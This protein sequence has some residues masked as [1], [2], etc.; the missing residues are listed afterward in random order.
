MAVGFRVF[1]RTSGKKKVYYVRILDNSGKV[2][3]TLSTGETNQYRAHA[4]AKEH[5]H[6]YDPSVK[7]PTL[8]EYTKDFFVWGKCDYVARQNAKDRSVCEDTAKDR[9][10]HLDYYILPKWGGCKLNEITAPAVEKWL[11]RLKSYKL[12]T[13]DGSG[14][15]LANSTKNQ[16]IYTLNII[17]RE[18]RRENIIRSVPQIEP[19]GNKRVKHRQP[20]TDSEIVLL[21]PEERNAFIQVWDDF[22]VGVLMETIMSTG[23]RSGEARGWWK[24]DVMP[25]AGAIKIFRQMYRSGEYGL[26]GRQRNPDKDPRRIALLPERTLHDI[27]EL[28]G[29]PPY[30]DTPLFMW[31]GEPFD[32]TYILKRLKRAAA[33]TIKREIDV[34]SLRYTYTSKMRELMISADVPDSILQ[35]LL[36]HKN[37]A[38]TD[39]Y[40]PFQLE[41]AIKK[42]LPSKPA[43]DEFWQIKEAV[44]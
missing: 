16:I 23:A 3:K 31:D 1:K 40:D 37:S 15:N 35:G 22:H 43:I 26:P 7:N 19:Y 41:R 21:F 25:E 44:S 6:E 42:A 24:S 4:W 2:I 36:G 33:K 38:V 34:H 20:L 8:A 11:L 27:Q 39:I 5:L 32:Q 13:E 9:R 18:A 28:I 14:H 10:G 30:D 29:H 17:L 12:K